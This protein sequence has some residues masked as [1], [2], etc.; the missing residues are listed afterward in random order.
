MTAVAQGEEV[1]TPASAL[2]VGAVGPFAPGVMPSVDREILAECP[3]LLVRL[4][5]DDAAFASGEVFDG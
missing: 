3:E 2:T 1:W 5:A 4:V